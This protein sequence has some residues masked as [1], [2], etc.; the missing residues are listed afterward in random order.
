MKHSHG[1]L[2]L[3]IMSI[4]VFVLMGCPGSDTDSETDGSNSGN[5]KLQWL[6]RTEAVT[7]FKYSGGIVVKMIF[8]QNF[9]I[10]GETG[11]IQIQGSMKEY[12]SPTILDEQ[13]TAFEVQN[14]KA[15]EAIIE[16][17][18]SNWGACNPGFTHSMVFSS[19]S[20]ASTRQVDL[21]SFLD[22][23]TN[24]FECASQYSI[25]DMSIQPVEG[26]VAGSWTG[27]SGFGSVDFHVSDDRTT[28]EEITLN[29]EDF[30]CGD[31]VSRSGSI[32]FS[33]DPGWSVNDG[34][35]TIQLT[36]SQTLDQEMLIQ[37]AFENSGTTAAGIFEA[38]V[39]DT[40]CQG[41][42]NTEPMTD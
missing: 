34:K 36:L 11:S 1:T 23:D 35:F 16:V 28:I 21:F 32:A 4:I 6:T 20:A 2:S 18:V 39:N 14:N 27:R 37:G 17:D 19:P 3:L 29:F 10:T 31:I 12:D 42:W 8:Y 24:F 7:K 26:P 41:I 33:N 30:S 38:D 15:Y 22:T 25:S 9:L 40:I 13:T 5:I